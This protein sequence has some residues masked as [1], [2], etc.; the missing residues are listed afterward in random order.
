MQAWMKELEGFNI[1]NLAPTTDGTCASDPSFAADAAK[2]GWWSC[3]GWTR[4]TG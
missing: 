1:P 2:R 3:G 4:N